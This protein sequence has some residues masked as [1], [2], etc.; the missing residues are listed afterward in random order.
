MFLNSKHVSASAVVLVLRDPV[1]PLRIRVHSEDLMG[2]EGN[3]GR[4]WTKKRTPPQK[5][6]KPL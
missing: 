2:A 5:R 4:G 3:I 1:T 6:T